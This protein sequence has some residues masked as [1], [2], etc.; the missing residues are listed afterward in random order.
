MKQDRSLYNNKVGAEPRTVVR[1]SLALLLPKL[2]EMERGDDQI[3][4]FKAVM[5]KAKANS[6]NVGLFTDLTLLAL[7]LAIITVLL[8]RERKPKVVGWFCDRDN[9]T[10]FNHGIVWDY[11]MENFQGI[12][13][14]FQVDVNDLKPVIAV[15]DRSSGEEVMWYDHYIRA[16]DWLAGALAAWDRSGNLVPTEHD[17]YLKLIEDVVADSQNII[18]LP[19]HLDEAGVRISR[20]IIG[21]QPSVE[22]ATPGIVLPSS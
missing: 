12:A 10:N 2:I 17:K 11:A 19:V 20:L 18:V 6:F 9:M 14:L 1:E 8:C 3:R 21:R 5:Q 7:Y 22:D 15:P 13:E 4:R 16:A